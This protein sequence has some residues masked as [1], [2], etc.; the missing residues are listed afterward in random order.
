M[1]T[2]EQPDSS[3]KRLRKAPGFKLKS[4]KR[5]KKNLQKKSIERIPAARHNGNGVHEENSNDSVQMQEK[6]ADVIEIDSSEDERS[7]ENRKRKHVATGN[8]VSKSH[9]KNNRSEDELLRNKP[10]TFEEF[11]FKFMEDESSN[12]NTRSGGYR[13]VADD[14]D[15]EQYFEILG[16]VN[17][18]VL[19]RISQLNENKS[20][21][22][23][24]GTFTCEICNREVV[25]RYNLKRHMMIHTNGKLR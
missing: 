1:N 10:L 21:Q 2:N 15:E 17:D 9:C 22:G 3:L 24:R 25:S 19:Q 5:F 6:P 18:E 7:L 11:G 12:S 20:Q 8:D 14:E 23:S 16:P 4:F 13:A